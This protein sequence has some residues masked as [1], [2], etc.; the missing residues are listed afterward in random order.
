[1]RRTLEEMQNR[2]TAYEV[3]VEATGTRT[4]LA[5]TARQ[6]KSRLLE[7]AIENGPAIIEMLGD[8]DGQQTYSKATGWTFGPARIFFTGGTERH[9]S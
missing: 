2:P 8:W 3:A 9:P 1:M 7:I 4:I 5:Y 6:T